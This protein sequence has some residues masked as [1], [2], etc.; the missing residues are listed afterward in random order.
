MLLIQC[1]GRAVILFF[2]CCRNQWANSS[3]KTF[4]CELQIHHQVSYAARHAMRVRFSVTFPPKE[5]QPSK[6]LN[7]WVETEKAKVTESKEK[8]SLKSQDPKSLA[9]EFHKRYV[10]K[11]DALSS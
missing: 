3:V 7:Y 1:S 6:V 2:R 10:E 5:M 8:S 4:V 11:R 9:E